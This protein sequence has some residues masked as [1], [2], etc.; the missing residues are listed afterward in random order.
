MPSCSFAP[1]FLISLD[2]RVDNELGPSAPW[3]IRLP[4]YCTRVRQRFY[5]PLLWSMTQLVE[6]ALTGCSPSLPSSKAG[7]QSA[8]TNVKPDTESVFPVSLPLSQ[9]SFIITSYSG[10]YWTWVAGLH[11]RA[12]SWVHFQTHITTDWGLK[13]MERR[14]RLF[15][16]FWLPLHTWDWIKT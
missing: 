6:V 8:A 15:G 1:V 14:E 3:L 11:P 4:L 13:Q 2:C 9:N 10:K 12:E 5:C 16:S 7:A